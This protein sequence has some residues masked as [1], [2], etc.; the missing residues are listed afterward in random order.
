MTIEIHRNRQRCQM[1]SALLD[2][3]RKSCNS[4]TQTLQADP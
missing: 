2:M 1:A 4:A 3:H